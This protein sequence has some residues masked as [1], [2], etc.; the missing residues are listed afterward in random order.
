MYFPW[1]CV[2][3]LRPEIGSSAA[4]KEDIWRQHHDLVQSLAL[5][6]GCLGLNPSSATY[7]ELDSQQLALPL[8]ASVYLYAV[9]SWGCQDM[10]W[11]LQTGDL[12]I[13]PL[14]L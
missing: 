4:Y 1:S 12:W 8:G 10:G 2:C 6:S 13:T 5:E 9:D 3:F 7:T 14:A 11:H